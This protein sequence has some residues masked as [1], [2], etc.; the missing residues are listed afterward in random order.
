MIKINGLQVKTL[1]EDSATLLNPISLEIST[2]KVVSLIGESGSGKSLLTRSIIGDLSNNLMY[3]GEII[4]NDVDYL[5]TRKFHQ[6]R[7]TQVAYIPQNPMRTFNNV[8]T[9]YSHFEEMLCSHFNYSKQ[10]MEQL[11]YDTLDKVHLSTIDNLLKSHPTQLSGGQLQR[12]MI[13]MNLCLNANYFLFDEPT[14]ALDKHNK[15]MITAVIKGLVK[16]NKG[17]LLVTHD[18]DL[19]RELGGEAIV[20]YKGNEIERNTAKL[21]LD[22]PMQEY[23]KQLVTNHFSRLIV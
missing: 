8:Q 5:N 9:I 12:I 11:M 13:A 7:G 16:D 22:A 6:I 10:Q 23:T 19:L 17:I 15:E 21:L 20:L 18:Y 4:I 14:S 2:G 3:T 1:S